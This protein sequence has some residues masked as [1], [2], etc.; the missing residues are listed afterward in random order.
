MRTAWIPELVQLYPSVCVSKIKNMDPMDIVL[1]LQ[2][3]ELSYFEDR[4]RSK[5]RVIAKNKI[6]K[7]ALQCA[8]N[9][10]RENMQE[11]FKKNRFDCPYSC[12]NVM[13]HLQYVKMLRNNDYYL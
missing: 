1:E 12:K 13:N 2:K 9:S 7:N 11:M 5:L 6:K 10:R 8:A 3:I 4:K